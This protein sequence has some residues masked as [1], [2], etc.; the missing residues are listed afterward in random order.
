MSSYSPSKPAKK[1]SVRPRARGGKR[2]DLLWNVLTVLLLVMSFCIAGYFLSIFVNPFTPF[3]PL[4][5][6]TQPPILTTATATITPLA[7]PATWTPTPTVE[8][9]PA[10]TLKPSITPLPSPTEFLVFTRTPTPLPTSTPTA[11]RTPRPV[12]AFTASTTPI[13]STIIHTEA[14]CNWLGVGG[15]VLDNKGNPVMGLV[16]VLGGSL[17]G[18]SVYIP[19]V[20]NTAP[21][22]GQGGFEFVLGDKPIASKNTLYIQLLDQAGIPLSDRIFFSTFNDCKKNLTIVRFTQVK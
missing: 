3:N 16:V 10:P 21:L 4:P 20:S 8:P 11:S 12:Y 5:P 22:Y 7:L 6:P 15:T 17:D 19:T 18:K 9:S 1:K 13:E 2:S 14:S